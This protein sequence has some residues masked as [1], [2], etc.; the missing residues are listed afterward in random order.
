MKKIGHIVFFLMKNYLIPSPSP[1][2][3]G[4]NTLLPT[5][6]KS[7]ILSPSPLQVGRKLNN[8]MATTLTL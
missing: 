6:W 2:G 3:E 5:V 7:Y 4:S 8:E 1:K